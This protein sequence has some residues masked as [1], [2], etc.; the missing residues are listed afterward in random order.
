MNVS[1]TTI[2]KVVQLITEKLEVDQNDLAYNASFA[3]DLGVDSLDVFEL[4][5]TVEKEFKINIPEEDADKLKTVGA[6]IDYIDE[7]LDNEKRN[8][9]KTE[10]HLH[11]ERIIK[12][13]NVSAYALSNA[14]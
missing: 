11:V 5:M 2:L 1:E 9:K 7:K 6:L 12:Q 13:E 8:N 4:I 10:R 14:G 3:D